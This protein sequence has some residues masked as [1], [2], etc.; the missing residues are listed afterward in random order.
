MI[1]S[2]L[3][4]LVREGDR[5]KAGFTLRNTTNRNME[6]DVSAKAEGISAPLVSQTVSLAP[7][8]A[9][10]IGWDVTASIGVET[11]KWEVEIKEKGT[12]ETDRIKV[13]QKVVPVVPVSTFQATLTQL[14]KEYHLSVERPKDAV[15]GRGGHQG[16]FPAENRRRA[17]RRD[18]LYEK[19]SLYLHGTDDLRGRCLTG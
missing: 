16:Q 1:L 10:E 4:P 18:R 2:G 11:L 8:E 19:I 6:V 17:E 7:G 14:E 13:A 12:N 15:P 3:P 9:K 5:F